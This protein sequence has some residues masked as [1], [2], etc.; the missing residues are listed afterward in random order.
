[1]YIS[2][3]LVAGTGESHVRIEQPILYNWG[4]GRGGG[5][6]GGGMHMHAYMYI[7]ICIFVY[8]YKYIDNM[9]VFKIWVVHVPVGGREPGGGV[10]GGVCACV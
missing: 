8:V 2:F 6:R 10:G 4:G 1:M 9:P 5:G 3:V 7:H